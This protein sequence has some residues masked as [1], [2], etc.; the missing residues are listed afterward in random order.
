MSQYCVSFFGSTYVEADS[1]EEAIELA[2]EQAYD[3][4]TA[5]C[6]DDEDEDE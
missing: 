4:M 1:E 6:E 2:M 5:E 3:Y